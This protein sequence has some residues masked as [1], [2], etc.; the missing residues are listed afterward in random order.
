MSTVDFRNFQVFAWPDGGWYIA[1]VDRS[2][3]HG[4]PPIQGL[5]NTYKS[6]GLAK[7]AAVHENTRPLTDIEREHAFIPGDSE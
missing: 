4:R 2:G 6:V 1:H 5:W 3:S 7:Q